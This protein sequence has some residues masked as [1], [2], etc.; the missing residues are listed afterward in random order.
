MAIFTS[1]AVPPEEYFG[2]VKDVIIST[3]YYCSDLDSNNCLTLV[4]ADILA[5]NCG[6]KERVAKKFDKPNYLYIKF[7]RR[8]LSGQYEPGKT[9]W[10]FNVNDIEN[11]TIQVRDEVAK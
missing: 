6:V 3:K 7:N 2:E 9:Q 4:A 5:V 11:I 8:L 1:R 10:L